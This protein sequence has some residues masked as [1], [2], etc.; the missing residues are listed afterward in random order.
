MG[1]S[2]VSGAQRPEQ[3]LLGA[4]CSTPAVSQAQ[5]DTLCN[6]VSFGLEV[7]KEVKGLWG[8]GRTGKENTGAEAWRSESLERIWEDESGM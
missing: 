4:L 3:P 6:L 5:G 2:P 7:V 8:A 1:S